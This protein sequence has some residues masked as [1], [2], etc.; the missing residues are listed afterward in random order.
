MGVGLSSHP[1]S[2]ANFAPPF[3][4]SKPS[5]PISFP[6]K[7]L[8][9]LEQRTYFDSFH[10]PFNR[11]SVPLPSYAVHGWQ[12]RKRKLLVCHDMAGGY[13]DDKWVQGNQNDAAYTIWHWYLMDVFVYFSHNLVTLPPPCWINAAHS[14]GVKALGTFITEWDE[15]RVV[16]NTL[17]ATKESARMYAARLAELAQRLGFDGWL[18]NI[19]VN[20]SSDQISNLTDFVKQLSLAMHSSVPG[21]LVIWYDAVTING[22]LNWQNQLNAKNKPFFDLCDG[23]FVN[24]SWKEDFPKSSA[25]L[26]GDRNY[27]VY[28]GIDVFGRGT[29]GGGQW[30]TKVALDVLKQ[31]SV[32]AAIFAPGWVYETNQQPDFR[33]AQNRWWGLVAKSWGLVQKNPRTLPFYSNFDQGVGRHIFVEGKLVYNNSW[34]NISCQSMQPVLGVDVDAAKSAIQVLV[35]FNEPSY[36]GAQTIMVTGRLKDN[37]YFMA[38]LFCGEVLLS[39]MPIHVSYSVQLKHNS[40]LGLALE[41]QSISNKRSMI[42]LAP[43]GRFSSDKV[44]ATGEVDGANELPR[45]FETIMPLQ[46]NSLSTQS[47]TMTKW[48]LNECS[49]QMPGHTLQNIYVVSY[50]EVSAPENADSTLT[51]STNYHALLGHITIRSSMKN[52]TFPPRNAW[53]FEG[54]DLFWSSSPE[55]IKTISVKLVWRL[56]AE[57]SESRPLYTRFNIYVRKLVGGPDDDITGQEEYL[58]AARVEAFYVSALAVEPNVTYL[59]FILQVCATDGTVGKLADAPVLLVAV[60]R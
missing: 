55:G 54:E 34:S 26:A 10:F 14:H 50:K 25:I 22:A 2:S 47:D 21:S 59:R 24:Y 38:L 7:T 37:H 60:P 9:E 45:K 32:S 40:L 18:V 41:F 11:A 33:T 15:G 1:P 49:L 3:D 35:N 13:L 51:S 48:I 57:S 46:V 20:L 19:E 53:A 16:C 36:S 27:D 8:E 23:I 52:M 28:M 12:E 30:N 43:E 4:P 56:E 6:I 17:L 39:D 29:Y 44:A 5:V 42:L 58:G 31:S